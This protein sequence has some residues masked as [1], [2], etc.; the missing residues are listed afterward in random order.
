M[1]HLPF[2]VSSFNILIVGIDFLCVNVLTW[3]I[4]PPGI[5]G[6]NLKVYILLSSKYA[7]VV[8][9]LKQGNFLIL[10]ILFKSIEIY[11]EYE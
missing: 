9:R 1:Y 8:I 6:V 7:N 4:L 3:K 5:T 11:V 2:H 10:K